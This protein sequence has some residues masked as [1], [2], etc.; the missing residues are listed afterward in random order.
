[1]A[2][3][4]CLEIIQT[5]WRARCSRSGSSVV[6]SGFNLNPCSMLRSYGR[7][8]I[9]LQGFAKAIVICMEILKNIRISFLIS[10]CCNLYLLNG[11]WC[12]LKLSLSD[13]W[14]LVNDQRDEQIP[15]YVFIFIYNF[16]HVSSTSCSSL[17]ETNCINTTSGNCHSVLVAVS[18]AGWEFIDT[19]CLSWWWARGARDMYRV[20][21]KNKYIKRNLCVTLVIYQE[22]LHD[23][24]STKC[25]RSLSKLRSNFI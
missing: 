10:F 5:V 7:I 13:S 1:M 6:E 23:A 16:L 21:N 8:F 24:R 14:F 9:V 20:I 12:T 17:G 4:Y 19:I 2:D 11:R 18:C 25:K 22:S 15:F 3:E